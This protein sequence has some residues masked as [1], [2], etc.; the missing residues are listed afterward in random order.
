[1][2]D[3]TMHLTKRTRFSNFFKVLRMS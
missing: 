2:R 1:M 3:K